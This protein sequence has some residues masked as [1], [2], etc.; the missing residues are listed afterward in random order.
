[1]RTAFVWIGALIFAGSL[2]S[3]V[4][5][6]GHLLGVPAASTTPAWP[7]VW[8]DI[9]LFTV[10][11]LHHSIMARTG[12]KTWIT[13]AVPADLERSLYV[14][15]ASLLF[16]A[17]CWLWRPLPGVAWA[18]EGPARWLL[19]SVQFAG[20]ALTERAA[21]FIGMW[22][23]AGVRQARDDRPVEFKVTGPFGLV[24]HPIYLG[25]VLMVFAAPV[26]T[27]SRLLF[28]VVSTV[29]LIAAIPWEEASLVETF[30]AKYRDYQRQV[31]SRL[32]PWIW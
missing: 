25:W 28:A 3:F 30:G 26:M 23:L 12:A 31:R 7:A 27:Y 19:F 24:R 17:V 10:F 4:V 2:G 1:M 21:R 5:V 15:V 29:Y 13:R 16:L 18:V 20:I 14:W 9:T 32:L 8:I 22:E 11:A 6:Y